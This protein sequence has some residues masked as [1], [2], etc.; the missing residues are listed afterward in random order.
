MTS[1]SCLSI[2]LAAGLG[3]R[4]KSNLPKVMH[5]I[6]GLP[7]VGHVV[8]ALKQAGSDRISVV[9]GPDMPELE[10]LVQNLAPEAHCHVQH[11][12]LGTAHAALA[13]R[14]ALASPS[15]DVLILFGD[16]PLV[17]A[18]TIGKVRRALSDGAD[19]AVLG[20][21]TQQP[22]GYGRL[23]TDNGQLVAIR[24]EK[25]ASDEERRIT[26]CNSGIMGFSGQHALSLLDAIGNANA[27]SEFYLTD[28]V[29]IANSRGLKVV[30]VSGSEV[31]TQGIN[32]RAQLAA[33]EEDFQVRM[34]NFAL[35]NG[36]TLLAPLTVY[37]SHDT[38]LEPDVVVEQNVVFAPGVKVASGA[39][40]R[41][42]SHLEGA[43]V[44]RNSAVGPYARL[45]PGAVLGA[46]TRVGNFVEVKNTT[47][48][49][50]A[51]ANHLS[52]IGDASVGSKSNIGAG[53][54]TCN[55]DGYLKH[56]TEI[57]AGSF[58]GSNSTLVAPVSLGSGTFVAAGS[59]ITDDVDQ[60][61]MAFGRARQIVK[62][63]K[64]KQLRER[65]KAAK[66]TKS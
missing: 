60:D 8:K 6:G 63:G 31:E 55:Y 1:R 36:C 14:S 43:S 44:G 56:R 2:V 12:R 35:D 9:T 49:D 34:R 65:L 24:E 28:A 26:F 16:T 45:R 32:T 39:R 11:E 53:T 4:M 22:F 15:D 52:Y 21:E 46:D 47:F 20:F 37:F 27:K 33:C 50:G 54:I 58:V 59:V 25:D 64:A 62:E 48:E 29:E 30:A 57:G 5:E 42:F 38:V 66:E 23:L 19:L 40:I 61:S 51:K 3:T 18:D 10:K 41:A 13:A 7:L 17:T